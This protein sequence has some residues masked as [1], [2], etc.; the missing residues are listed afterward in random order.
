VKK[1][2]PP[3]LLLLSLGVVGC[4]DTPYDVMRDI[5]TLRNELADEALRVRDE[6][7]AK[8]TV[9]GRLKKMKDRDERIKKRLS[10]V[11]EDRKKL[12]QFEVAREYLAE[13]LAASGGYL[14]QAKSWLE[15]VSREAG[16]QASAT[17][18]SVQGQI[19]SLSNIDL[20]KPQPK[21]SG[22]PGK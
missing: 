4:G 9:E 10:D 22:A 7:S 13:E 11:K 1:T 6:A 8:A 18:Q 19:D 15:A 2:V 5:I 21:P 20:P 3:L 17:I 12:E 16:G 14:E